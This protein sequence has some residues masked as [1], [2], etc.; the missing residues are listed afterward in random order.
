MPEGLETVLDEVVK[1]VNFVKGRPLN[2]RLFARLC[3]DIGSEY[4]Q[5][6][7]H[8]DVRWL[9]RRQSSDSCIPASRRA[10]AI[11]G[12]EQLQFG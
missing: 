12:Q 4:T 9:S 2:A 8:T 6:L 7:F 10:S 11:L 3:E 5:L 1:I